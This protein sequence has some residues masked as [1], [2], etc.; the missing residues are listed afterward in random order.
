MAL[1]EGAP[2]EA[3]R[4]LRSWHVSAGDRRSR[5]EKELFIAA[6]DLETGQRDTAMRRAAPALEEAAREGDVRLVLDAG[7]AV[8]AVLWTLASTSETPYVRHLVASAA[9][10]QLAAATVAGLSAREL[11]VVRYLP[12]PLSN[13]EIAARLFVSLNTLKTHL[14]SIYRKLE[15]RGRREAARKAEELGIA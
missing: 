9:R 6:V 11:E 8:E 7:P 10:P 12:T 15:V 5:L 2:A 4:A 1:A 3:R 14:R 13:A